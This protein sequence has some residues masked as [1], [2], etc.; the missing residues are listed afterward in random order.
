MEI[1]LLKDVDNVGDK[2]TI[3]KVKDGF[4]RNYLIPRG[5]ALVANS[6]NRRKLNEIIRLDELQE[7][8]RLD[9]YQEMANKLAGA[10][11]RI[12]AKAGTS[13]KI[14][15]SVNNSQLAAAI[16]EQFELEIERR[17]IE[18]PEE[19][20][21]LGTYTANINLHKEVKATVTFEVVEDQ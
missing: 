18:I 2:H 13:G 14:F 17:K 9:V 16:K 7:S 12:G 21:T 8:K 15:G 6:T 11:L 10:T 20:K 5:L 19:V 1:I 4:G 3:V